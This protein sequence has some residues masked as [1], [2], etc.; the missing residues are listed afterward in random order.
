MRYKSLAYEQYNILQTLGIVFV[1][2]NIR[3]H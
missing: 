3:W 2:T 1:L